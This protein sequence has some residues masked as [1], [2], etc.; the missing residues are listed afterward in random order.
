MTSPEAAELAAVD[1]ALADQPVAAEHAELA[2]LALLLRDDT[3]QPTA[4]WAAGLDRRVKDGFPARPRRRLRINLGWASPIAAVAGL[5]LPL[6]VIG[7]I[8]GSS[9]GGS[10]DSGESASSGSGGG[11]SAGQQEGGSGSLAPDAAAPQSADSSG[12]AVAP[13]PPAPRGGGDPGSDGRRS[14]S[15]ERSASLTLAAPPR[16]IDRVASG[17]GRVA[18]SLGGFVSASSITSSDGGTLDLRVPSNRLDDAIE[19]ISR[20]ADVRRLSRESLDITSSVV[21][22][23]ERLNDARAER[24]SLLRQLEDAVTVNETES[25]RARLRIVSGEIASARTRL[26]RVDNRARFANVTVALEAQRGGEAGG[27]WTPG[28]A[29]DDAVRVLEVAAGVLLI[30][31]AVLLPLALAGLLGW[32]GRRAL[33]RRRRERA[34]DMA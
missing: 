22:A 14:R 25:I 17:V 3:P 15:V 18:A 9:G 8:A 2:A 5:L 24:K 29:A 23:R 6:I 30:A 12:S 31:A 19:R 21:S 32:G 27:S 33:T 11:A 16:D 4:T 28:D 10:D 26:R 34:L 7:V 13:A 20:L 1:A